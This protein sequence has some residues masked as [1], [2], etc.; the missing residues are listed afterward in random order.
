MNIKFYSRLNS[1]IFRI[2]KLNFIKQLSSDCN[3]QLNKSNKSNENYFQHHNYFTSKSS[4]HLYKNLFPWKTEFELAKCLSDN[5]VYNDYNLVAIS[6]PWGLC[7]HKS[8]IYNNYKN[9]PGLAEEQQNSMI[10][11]QSKL[12]VADVLDLLA[13]FLNVSNLYIAKC[14]SNICFYYF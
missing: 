3:F 6:K 1:N 12:A 14:K 10:V 9:N 11:G 5:V 2:N 13:Q 4:G 7:I 8:N